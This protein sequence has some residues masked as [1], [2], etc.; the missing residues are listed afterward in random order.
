MNGEFSAAERA[1]VHLS[2]RTYEI[3]Y[4]KDYEK[5]QMTNGVHWRDSVGLTHA[6]IV[7]SGAAKEV[8]K[9]L[10]ENGYRKVASK[11]A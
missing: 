6:I 7:R 1:L 4:Y 11:G 5:G 2:N 8:E 9:L 3:T 10:V